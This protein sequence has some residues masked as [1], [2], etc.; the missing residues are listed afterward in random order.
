MKEYKDEITLSK[1][2]RGCYILDTVKGCPM[3][4]K[5][6]PRGCYGDCYAMNIASRY[7]FNFA[8]ENRRRIKEDKT[9]LYLF[10]INNLTH[11]TTIVKQIKNADMPFVRIGEMGDPSHD[12]EHTIDVCEEIKDSGKAIVIVTKHWKTLT[13]AQC[14]RIKKLNVCVNTSISALDKTEEIEKRISEFFRLE[15][16]CKSVLRIVTC[17]FNSDNEIGKQKNKVQEKLLSM[18]PNHIETVFRPS[19]INTL[20]TDGIIKVEKVAFI[21]KP[22][23]VSMRSKDIYFGRCETCSDMCGIKI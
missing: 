19:A 15:F 20:V 7:G 12:W 23:L 5:E 9:Q 21:N 3:G 18:F 10:G 13:T 4:V 14:E 8:N 6:N 17:Y 2:G 22:V 1:N 11:K 16:Y